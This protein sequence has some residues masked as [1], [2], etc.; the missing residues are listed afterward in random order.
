M[1]VKLGLTLQGKKIIHRGRKKIRTSEE[2]KQKRHLHSEELYSLYILQ[3]LPHELNERALAG[4]L[5]SWS[6]EMVVVTEIASR[7]N[8]SIF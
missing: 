1:G 6:T 5:M 3:I 7:D 2:A 8:L 4:G